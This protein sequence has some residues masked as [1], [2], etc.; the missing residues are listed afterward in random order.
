MSLAFDLRQ[1]LR[2]LCRR[3]AYFAAT[4]ASLA[5]VLAANATLFATIN[6]TLF[7]PVPFNSG[8]RTINIY[9]CPPGVTDPSGWNP[10]HAIDLVR[11]RQPHRTFRD[12][13][14]YTVEDRT[15][16]G[17]AEP[18][19]VK[20]LA[21][22]ASLFR[23]LPAAPVV[24]RGFSEEEEETRARV[25][26]LTHG[27]WQRRFAGE[28]VVG[29][30]L[31]IDGAAYTIIGV[32]PPSF[33]P[34]S[35]QAGVVVPL[36]IASRAPTD[37]PNRTYL[38]N[39]A[40][41][42]DGA[43]LDQARAE[44]QSTMAALAQENPR[45]HAGWTAGV[46][47]YRE[48][49]YGNLRSPL[50]ALFA[51]MTLLLLIASTN[52]A[53]LTLAHVSSRRG[54]I[55]LRRAIGASGAAV[56]RLILTEVAIVHL[57]GAAVG[58]ALA[59]RILPALL[60][61][62]PAATRTL[63]PVSMDWR[64]AAYAFLSALAAALVASLA[65]AAHASDGNLAQA[66]SGGARAGTGREGRRWRSALI[67]A[68]TALCLVLLD[69]GGLL[70]RAL[71]RSSAIAPGYDP[72]HVLTAQLR[73]PAERYNSP[74]S[75]VLVMQQILDR[76]RSMPGVVEASQTLNRFVPPQSFVTLADVEGQPTPN[77]TARTF[78]FRR[79]SP[80]YFATMRIRQLRGRLF[81]DRDTAEA[82]PVTI[83]S[84]GFAERFWPGQDAVGH[85][86]TRATGKPLTIV[87]VVD[88]VCDV[89]LLQPPQDTLYLPW[90]QSNTTVS[91]IALVVRVEGDP[92]AA[93][94]AVRAAVLSVDRA[95]P[96]DRIQPL[97]TFLADSLAPQRF[98]ASLL[99]VLAAIGLLLGAIG[100]AGVTAR[101]IAERMR[102]FGVRLALGSDQRDLWRAA[103][104]R[105]LRFAALGCVAGLALSLATGRVLRHLL[106]EVAGFDLVPMLVAAAVLLGTSV[107]AAA[108]PA[109]RVLRLDAV[110][111]LRA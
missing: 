107:L 45:T 23:L 28:P 18:E 8:D 11:Y 2:S 76:I 73:L 20:T 37:T 99:L 83:I 65:P 82:T 21:V 39:L 35:I 53:S 103:I 84:R 6:A 109:A 91:P 54:E 69:S 52:I 72:S 15:L 95:L 66:F 40:R 33:P 22:N 86:L 1:A 101:S 80:T 3:P 24:G 4:V 110:E 56:A 96:L 108:V 43:T 104:L 31:E 85:R 68:Q 74:Q 32:L 77:G 88:D 7:R 105:E 71:G 19:L 17:A 102:E 36:G 64:V 98:R 100:V 81:D 42:N 13:T 9:T 29:R 51:A 50:L 58:I 93:A 75:R 62:Y 87:G 89:D 10:F 16:T 34:P 30:A 47:T 46:Q 41:L 78:L 14:G 63:G 70:L 79:I 106:P 59:V 44:I 111:V 55:A 27:L 38:V 92:G 49:Q 94:G 67:V 61:I 60:S 90:S 48:W 12:V 25:V 26:V 5:L 57:L 97:E